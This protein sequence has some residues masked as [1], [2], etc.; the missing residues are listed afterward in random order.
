MQ[1]KEALKHKGESEFDEL[2]RLLKESNL[3]K[4]S[5]SLIT[6]KKEYKKFDMAKQD[7]LPT[8]FIPKDGHLLVADVRYESLMRQGEVR[9]RDERTAELHAQLRAK[10]MEEM[11]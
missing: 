9:R 11:R 7:T 4:Q 2:A 5:T 6:M 8:T 3:E 10:K 1:R